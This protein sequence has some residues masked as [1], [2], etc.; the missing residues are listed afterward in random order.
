MDPGNHGQYR[1]RDDQ[2][3][4][5]ALIRKRN[6]LLTV[7]TIANLRGRSDYT[8]E[9]TACNSRRQI[10]QVAASS[11]ALRLQNLQV[12]ALTHRFVDF[13]AASGLTLSGLRN[14]ESIWEDTQLVKFVIALRRIA[15]LHLL[16]QSTSIVA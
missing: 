14:D 10:R 4:E 6:R 12:P 16:A 13:F 1:E 7:H 15:A 11:P 9:G 2:N 3:E 5:K 8:H